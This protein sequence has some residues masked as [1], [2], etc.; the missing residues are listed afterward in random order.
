MIS[1]IRV[2]M[3]T[4]SLHSNR[5]L[6]KTV[7]S[8]DLSIFLKLGKKLVIFIQTFPECGSEVEDKNS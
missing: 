7:R 2:A 8:E 4:V 5:T 3:V 6:D 1:F